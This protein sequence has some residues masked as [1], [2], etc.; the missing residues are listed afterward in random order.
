M[1]IPIPSVEGAVE[2]VT[3]I[4]CALPPE[5]PG[6]RLPRQSRSRAS[7]ERI[8]AAAHDLSFEPLVV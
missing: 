4:E 6:V 7:F 5:I 8:L 1:Q 3:R 2:G